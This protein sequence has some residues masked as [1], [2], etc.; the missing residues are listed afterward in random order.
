MDALNGA[1]VPDL[2][3]RWLRSVRPF[4]AVV[5]P[6]QFARS[7]VNLLITS[8]KD[9][10]GSALQDDVMAMP[11]VGMGRCIRMLEDASTG[12]NAVN[13]DPT[14]PRTTHARHK[15]HHQSAG[16]GKTTI[17]LL[18]DAF[19]LVIAWSIEML[20]GILLHLKDGAR[21]KAKDQAINLTEWTLWVG[22]E[23][24]IFGPPIGI[25]GDFGKQWHHIDA[26]RNAQ[27]VF[28]SGRKFMVGA[29]V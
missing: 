14:E 7:H 29:A 11:V 9:H 2:M 20:F 19:V 22:A 18:I 17:N 4:L 21:R 8:L 15:L 6:P 28:H 27:K 25:S 10:A 26:L 5:E 24:G 1:V 3:L 13:D 12:L 23:I 16:L